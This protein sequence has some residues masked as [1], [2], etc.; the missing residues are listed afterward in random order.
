MK[1]VGENLWVHEDTM[2]MAGTRLRLRMTIVKLENGCLWVHSPTRISPQLKEKTEKLGKVSFIVAASNGHNI[3]LP[4]WQE[5]FPD[6]VLYVSSGI[7]KKLKLTNYTV[8]AETDEGLWQED[9]A[10]EYMPG[11]PFFNESVFLHKKTKSLIVTDLIQNHSD[12]RPSG[13]AGFVTKYIIEPIGFKGMCLAPP[14]KLGFM[15]K[16]K[17]EFSVFIN[18]IL[19]WDFDRI[20]VTHGDIIESDAKGVFTR[21]CKRFIK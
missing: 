16:N 19:E 20:I 12:K 6:A 4:E 1:A 5:A 15:I 14:L 13:F 21:L 10:R 18:R 9:L 3:W 2:S 7:P 17:P 8:L 11:V